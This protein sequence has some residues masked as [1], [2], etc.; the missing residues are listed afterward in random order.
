VKKESFAPLASGDTRVLVLGSMPGERS[1]AVGEY[2]GHPQNRFWRV[3]ATLV[4]EDTPI[5]YTDKKA[6]LARAGI[7][8]WDVAGRAFREGS[9]DSAIR[10]VEPNDIPAFIAAH[11]RLRGSAFNGRTPQTR[12][13]R[14]F[15]R[16]PGIEY[17]S[18]PSTSPAN[19][20]FG[21]ERL[22]EKWAS[23]FSDRP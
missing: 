2:Y 4:G 21:F 7:G 6:M 5:S 1:L 13:A 10:E 14:F 12:H 3:M 20:A 22:L 18:L 8:L 9:L 15:D 17:L 11:P 16:V 19:A 23:I